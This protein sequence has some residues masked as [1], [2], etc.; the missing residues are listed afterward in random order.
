MYVCMWMHV[1]MYMRI[2]MHMRMCV[3]VCVRVRVCMCDWN[4]DSKAYVVMS[5]GFLQ[6]LNAAVKAYDA[7]AKELPQKT[8]MKTSAAEKD[9]DEVGEKVLQ[10]VAIRAFSKCA[11][12]RIPDATTPKSKQGFVRECKRLVAALR[13]QGPPIHIPKH[14]REKLEEA[15]NA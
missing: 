12:K 3:C 13:P 15:A 8:S 14:F 11:L 6:A 10:T 4:M 1:C 2:C 9:L 7:A 5:A